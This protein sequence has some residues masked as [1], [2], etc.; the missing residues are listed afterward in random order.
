MVSSFELADSIGINQHFETFA[1]NND[2]RT[3]AAQMLLVDSGIKHLRT[4]IFKHDSLDDW[5]TDRHHEILGELTDAGMKLTVLFGWQELVSGQPARIANAEQ[6]MTICDTTY[7]GKVAAFEG[8]NE[9]DNPAVNPGAPSDWRKWTLEQHVAIRQARDKRP[10]LRG[11]PILGPSPIGGLAQ[12]QH[13][14]PIDFLVDA[15]NTHPYTGNQVATSAFMAQHVAD[16][17][18]SCPVSVKPLYATEYGISLHGDPWPNVT[19]REQAILIVRQILTHAKAG[20]VRSYYY[21]FIDDGTV[22]HRENRFGLLS[23]DLTPRPAYYAVRK[24]ISLCDD[25]PA[26]HVPLTWTL[27]GAPADARSLVLTCADGSHLV[28][29]WREAAL[30]S[31]PVTAQVTFPGK[32]SKVSYDLIDGGADCPYSFPDGYG[33]NIALGDAP[34]VFRV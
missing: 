2:P 19:E 15:V 30:G 4:P 10:A 18:P 31:T 27:T 11:V 5:W 17:V 3:T 7:A 20:V 14:G 26:A 22:L 33:I 12:R 1:L 13:L 21:D 29:L 25:E 23:Y 32:T 8:P 28:L 34:V 6:V 16:A 24:L 9:P